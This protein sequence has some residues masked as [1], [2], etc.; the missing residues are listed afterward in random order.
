MKH[1]LAYDG[2]G[3]TTRAGLYDAEGHL[4]AEALGGASNP[5]ALGVNVCLSVLVQVGRDAV[6]QAGYEVDA[7]GVA[8]SGAWTSG[9]GVWL[10]NRL[11]ERFRAARAVVC[12]DIRPILFANIGDAPGILAIAGTGA[13]VVA[14]MPD[15][16]SDFVGGR[17]AAFGDDGSAFQIGQS[18][19]KA[20]AKAL[21]GLGP[22]T[23]LVTLL[24]QAA[25]VDSFRM[26]A[27]WAW[28]ASM[29]EIAGLA[30]TVAQAAEHDPVAAMCITEQARRMAEQVRAGY[31]KLGLPGDAPVL[32]NGGVFER[33]PRYVAAFRAHLVE[34]GVKPEPQL[35]RVRGHRAA[36]EL[37][38]ANHL[39]QTL[40]ASVGHGEP[41]VQ[42]PPTE[43]RAEGPP[44]DSLSAGE[45][46]AAMNRLDAE[47]PEAVAR[48]SGA[49]A[50]AMEWAAEALSGDGRLI[51][52]GAGT[53]GRLGV[54]DAAECPPTFGVPP[55]RVVGLIA[56]GD[57]ALRES[58]EGAEDD[59]AAAARDLEGLSPALN[60]RDMVV[61]IAASGTT[62]YTL[63]G[64]A[65][66]RSVGAK[67]VFLCC[68][69]EA[70]SP[71]ELTIAI[72]TGPEA[73]GG[74]TRLKAG[75]ATKLVLNML[76]T[77]AMALS[78]RVFEG[79][80]VAMRPSNDKLQ[81]RA[82]RMLQS[83]LTVTPDEAAQLLAE[84]GGDIRVAVAMGRLKINA[85]SARKALA[86]ASWNLRALLD[87]P[88][89]ESKSK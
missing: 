78:G 8:L 12:D 2:G 7:I 86:G 15:G 29:R 43:C 17:G 67:T 80:M 53:S 5:V 75:T 16:R 83:L 82:V 33:C 27:P 44:L 31:R 52:L 24:P 3:T 59:T 26:L 73:I 47:V 32:L 81:N 72:E 14:Q 74:S 18:A 60:G 79:L 57:A 25:G 51:Y 34:L 84:A 48:V 38:R 63:A 71:A 11:C 1:Y 41:A 54:L 65:H 13:S 35:A 85:N 4:L 28:R 22:D 56:G 45:I 6:A 88:S 46:V 68:N 40:L 77:G 70:A 9:M 69:P 87:T 50:R 64:L 36:L 89:R 19:L 61:G 55:G 30:E 39:P 76:S 37:V 62:P 20:A 66:A 58:V 49:I 21:D 23:A 42:Q 10:A